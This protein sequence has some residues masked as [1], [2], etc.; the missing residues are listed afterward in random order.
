MFPLCTVEGRL[1]LSATRLLFFPDRVV[2]G[3][4]TSGSTFVSPPTSSSSGTQMWV[5]DSASDVCG[6]C[7][8]PILPGLFL[9]RKHHCRRCVRRGQYTQSHYRN[10]LCLLML[11]ERPGFHVLVAYQ[12][13]GYGRCCHGK[14]MCWHGVML[15]F[16]HG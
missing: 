4:E 1:E 13:I 11:R 10:V 14:T 15:C 9:S 8:N 5:P 3:E 6:G 12:T 2:D 16:S 7:Q